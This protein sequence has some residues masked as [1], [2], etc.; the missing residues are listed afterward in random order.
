MLCKRF[1]IENHSKIK[2]TMSHR[3]LIWALLVLLPLSVTCYDLL[4]KIHPLPGQLRKALSPQWDHFRAHLGREGKKDSH[5]KP[6]AKNG[7]PKSLDVSRVASKTATSLLFLLAFSKRVVATAISSPSKTP[8]TIT[9]MQGL[10]IW[11]SLFLLSAC[12]HGAE[13]AMTKISPWRV[14]E[15]AEEEGKGSPFVTLSEDL[16][17]LLSTILLTTTACSIYGTALFVS[18]MQG[19]FPKLSLG[20]ISGLLTIVTL[21]FGE[22]LPKAIA[23]SNSELIVRSTVRPLAKLANVL[24][25][26]TIS[27]TTLSSLFL[28]KLKLN[29]TDDN[30][31]SEDMLRMVVDEAAKS[32]SIDGIENK[33]GRMIKA[34]LDMEETPVAKIMRPRIDIEAIGEDAT[35]TELLE[36][37]I[38]TKYSRIPV[39]RDDID[40]IIGVVFSKDLLDFILLGFDIDKSNVVE[41]ETERDFVEIEDKDNSSESIEV[42]QESKES[43]RTLSLESIRNLLSIDFEGVGENEL[44]PTGLSFATTKLNETDSIR[45]TYFIPETMTTW[46]ALQEMRKRRVHMAIVVDEYG[47]TAGLVTFEDI[48]E[49]VVGEI[50]DEG[51]DEDDIEEGTIL[52]R[53][54]GVFEIKGY[55]ELD[56]VYEA[57]SLQIDEEEFKDTSGDISTIGGLLC[58]QAGQIPVAGYTIEFGGYL[59]SVEEVDDRRILLLRAVRWNPTSSKPKGQGVEE[60]NGEESVD[61]NIQNSNHFSESPSVE[62]TSSE[63]ISEKDIPVDIFSDNMKSTKAEQDHEKHLDELLK[64]TE[65]ETEMEGTETSKKEMEDVSMDRNDV[66]MNV[67]GRESEGMMEIKEDEN[68]MTFRDGE[69]INLDDNGTNG[70]NSNGSNGSNG[71]GFNGGSDESD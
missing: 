67:D 13:S 10:V 51:D 15:V 12:L 37:S 69:W 61:E 55:A 59:F 70:S 19:F 48:L 42:E 33:E 68:V 31:V 58:S 34:V 1:L 30:K 39:F 29:L 38:A 71:N 17:K 2:T 57:L 26:I 7:F 18:T 14:K 53:E 24:N 49:E 21:F 22:I 41:S 52:L 8:S 25:P 64:K 60:G 54:G 43:K 23:V 32:T 46:N 63:V 11:V 44:T 62:V 50:Y 27:F 5:F 3:G 4:Y 40:N 45:S 66:S 35:L 9:P 47:G 36:A 56:D 65:T 20:Y 28:R 6:V 16:T